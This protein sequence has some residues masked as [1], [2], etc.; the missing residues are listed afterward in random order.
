M[1]GPS[2]MAGATTPSDAFSAPPTPLRRLT[3]AGFHV[4]RLQAAL[5]GRR[6]VVP[7]DDA[8]A[9]VEIG[10][11]RLHDRHRNPGVQEVHGDAAAHG[12]G[13]DDADGPDRPRRR[14]LRQAGDLARLP[15]GEEG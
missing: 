5:G 10:P 15:L 9:P 11:V 6:L 13:P 1:A 8:D 2:F 7:A 12:A 4:A 14:P 3:H